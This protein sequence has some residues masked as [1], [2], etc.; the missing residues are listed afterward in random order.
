MIDTIRGIVE[1]EQAELDRESQKILR[2]KETTD[3]ERDKNLQIWLAIVG[4][5]LTVSGLSAAVNTKPITTIFPTLQPSGSKVTPV[6]SFSF[7]L[8]NVLVHLFIGL[9][10]AVIFYPLITRLVQKHSNDK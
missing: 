2:N 6:Y 9:T 7:D 8:L 3:K 10:A 4:S 1:I 5:G